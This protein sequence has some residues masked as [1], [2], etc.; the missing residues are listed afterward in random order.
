MFITLISGKN[1]HMTLKRSSKSPSL[2]PIASP[3]ILNRIAQKVILLFFD[4][5]PNIFK[6]IPVLQCYF[7]F[8][9]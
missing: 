5:K 6:N 2:I 1:L 3:N 8:L 4:K 7:V 9:L